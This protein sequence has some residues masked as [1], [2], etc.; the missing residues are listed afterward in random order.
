MTLTYATAAEMYR[1]DQI[2]ALADTP[3]GFRFLLLRSLSRA[4]HMRALAA[5]VG[6]DV[7][8]IGIREMLPYLYQ[9]NITAE[10]IRKFIRKSFAGER[11]AR[12]EGEAAL[13]SE[14][15][16]MNEFRWGGPHQNSLEKTIVDNH[17]KKI[18]RY[19]ILN[20]S[21]EGKLFESMQGYVRCS[22]YNH[23]TAIMIEDIFKEHHRV[24]PAIGRVKKIDFFVDDTPFDLKVTHLPEGFVKQA[25]RAQ[26][27]RPELTL[28]KQ[29][30][31]K[32]DMEIDASLSSASL[33]EHLWRMVADHPDR[34]GATLIRE[35]KNTRDMVVEEIV[36]NPDMLTRWLY[37]N[38]GTRR[39]DAAN[40]LFLVL[41]DQR[42]H[43]DSWKLKRNRHLIAESVHG[44][45]QDSSRT[46]GREVRFEWEGASHIA[47]ADVILVRQNEV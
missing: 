3:Q 8:A 22:W 31:R 32:L 42:N 30:A 17:V 14:L 18:K 9:S 40:R 19:D 38:Q 45:F 27:M 2:N 34:S 37:E 10:Q 41:I 28:L 24:L 36:A 39:F 4:E 6:L 20:E 46:F 12:K 44:H 23:W 5:H 15:Y 16:K 35:L 29:A 11:Q 13:I 1:N 7:S 33:L 21:I 47:Q 26:G 43:F 25:R